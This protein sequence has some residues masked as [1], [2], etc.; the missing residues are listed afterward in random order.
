MSKLYEIIIARY[1]ENVNWCN[2]YK[3]NIIIYNKGNDNIP[4][5]ISL[6][7]VGREN[8]T[9]LYHIVNHYDCLADKTIFCQ[10]KH[11]SYFLE[12]SIQTKLPFEI[13]ITS[14]VESNLKNICIRRGYD[15]YYKDL[16]PITPFPKNTELDKWNLKKNF[17]FF[18]EY[19]EE[20]KQ[21]QNGIY[22]LKDFWNT[23]IHP[24]K[25]IP[26]ILYYSQENIFSVSKDIIQKKPKEY[27]ERLLKQL[28][29]NYNPYQTYYIQWFWYYIFTD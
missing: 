2:Q 24:N 13:F 8:H 3:E 12:Y 25:P 4:N 29:Y 10:G 23:F 21:K 14:F 17:K 5:S 16:K 15:K 7:N 28:E 22:N 6:N 27:Y 18:K 20:L 19:L 26:S 11:C 1:N 9:Y